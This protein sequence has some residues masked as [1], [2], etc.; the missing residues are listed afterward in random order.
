MILLLSL[1]FG[2]AEPPPPPGTITDRPGTTEVTIDGEAITSGMVESILGRMPPQQAEQLKGNPADYHAFVEQIAV[3][4]KLWRDALKGG[5]AEKPGM[6]TRLAMAQQEVLVAAYLEET[7]KAAVNE[8]AVTA[9]YESHKVQFAKPSLKLRHILVK[10]GDTATATEVLGKLKAGADFD[11]VAKEVSQDR[12]QSPDLGW[13]PKGKLVPELD[14]AVFEGKPGDII[15]PVETKFGLHILK[16]E[17]RRDTVPIEDVR[18]RIEEQLK[19][20][21]V[22]KLIDD[23]KAASK[24]EWPGAASV[25]GPVEGAPGG[26]PPAGGDAPPPPPPPAEPAAPAHP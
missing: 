18:S 3:G 12:Q 2:C 1:F 9:W 21:A 23:A 24:I 5:Y 4:Q 16:V 8:Q 6:K 7:G 26:A 22:K 15:G 13:V 20:E 14:S 25:G 11:T 19:Q 10:S 17:D